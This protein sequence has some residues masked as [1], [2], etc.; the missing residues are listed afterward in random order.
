MIT[1]HAYNAGWPRN[2]SLGCLTLVAGRRG[3]RNCG[4]TESEHAGSEYAPAP[5]DMH[6]PKPYT[7]ELDWPP[8]VNQTDEE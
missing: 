2:D 3:E 7:G 4:A 5:G 8:V 1:N 6:E